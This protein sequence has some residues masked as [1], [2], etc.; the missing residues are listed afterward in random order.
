M[1]LIFQDVESK[2]AEK[3][4]K[5]QLSYDNFLKLCFEKENSGAFASDLNYKAWVAINGEHLLTKDDHDRQEE[6]NRLKNIKEREDRAKAA[7]RG[8][9]RGYIGRGRG[10]YV[11]DGEWFGRGGYGQGG[12][13]RGGYWRGFSG[14][15]AEI[16]NQYKDWHLLR[17]SKNEQ[18]TMW[19][20]FFYNF[21]WKPHTMNLGK[22][23]KN[24]WN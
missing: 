17:L 15:K 20:D 3:E 19:N 13:G 10:G 1:F 21:C 24:L 14:W 11:R 5:H 12:Y 6:E 18:W 9:K 23:Y 2:M 22:Y 8:R 16:V 4:A 7:G